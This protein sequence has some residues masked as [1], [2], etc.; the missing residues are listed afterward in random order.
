MENKRFTCK[1]NSV[2]EIEYYDN[3]RLLPPEKVVGLLNNYFEGYENMKNRYLDIK[4][5]NHRI[6]STFISI[7]ILNQNIEWLKE[8]L[9]K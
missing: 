1:K 3:D 8:N 2:D 9:G 7:D 6:Q 4:Q 5:E